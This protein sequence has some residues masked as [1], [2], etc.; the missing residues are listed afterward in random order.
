[1]PQTTPAADEIIEIAVNAVGSECDSM[2]AALDQLDAAVY[3]TDAQ[4]QV[5]FFNRACI[6]FAG[7]I[8]VAGEDRW[9]VT[10]KLY[11]ENG[12]PLPHD[13]CPMAV[14]I[15]E[16]RAI[17]GVEAV[18]ER[19]DGSRIAFMPFPTPVLDEEGNLVGAVNLLVD[20]SGRKHGGQLLAQAERCRR[21][22]GSVNDQHTVHTLTAMAAEYETQA[23]ALQRPN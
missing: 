11:T 12:E 23:K 18:A 15:R 7:R 14:A 13:Q 3:I 2:R 22:A 20:I 4:G 8:P 19:P 6:G 21:L 10:W 9:C 1:M 16:K 5:T 17:R